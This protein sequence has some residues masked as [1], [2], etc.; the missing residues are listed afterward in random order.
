MPDHFAA[1]SFVDRITDFEAGSRARGEFAVP[2]GIAAFP[3]CLVAEAVG[4]LAAWV[5]M[6]KISFRGRPVAALA[7]ETLFHGEVKPGDKLELGVEIEHC[8]DDAVAYAGWARVG[9]R[10]VIELK[11]CLGP[12]L[13]VEEFD[14]PAALVE[15]LALLR[16]AGAEPARFH[17]VVAPRL[18]PGDALA[19][20][21]V[22]ATLHIPASAAFFADHFPRRPVFPATLLLDAQIGMAMQLAAP[23]AVPARMTHVKMR[24][25][26]APG[27]VLQIEAK[28]APADANR[29]L[30]SA[31]SPDG[32]T[33][34]TARLETRPGKPG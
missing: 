2:R 21:S 22:S 26:I 19:G 24:S 4:Q 25:F 9:G 20:A 16:G 23:G 33:V 5:A 10:T 15:R 6:A 28:R 27:D 17:G 14:S 7:N 31:R 29:I 34:A 30:L 32:K 1:F 8:D 18:V 13:P 3:S 11:D 12:M